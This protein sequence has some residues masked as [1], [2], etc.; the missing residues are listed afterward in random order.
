MLAQCLLFEVLKGLPKWVFVSLIVQVPHPMSNLEN[1]WEAQ[2]NAQKLNH[3]NCMVKAFSKK[4]LVKLMFLHV[5][6]FIVQFR[7]V[8]MFF[9]PYGNVSIKCQRWGFF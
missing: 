3:C 7:F 1:Q 2:V 9:Y 8:N 4:P 6:Y 5:F